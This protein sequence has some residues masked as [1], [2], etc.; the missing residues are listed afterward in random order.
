MKRDE[1]RSGGEGEEK[2]YCEE[3]KN[4]RREKARGN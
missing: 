1:E 2:G 3:R 4:R